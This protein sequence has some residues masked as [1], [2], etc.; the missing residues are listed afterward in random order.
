MTGHVIASKDFGTFYASS[1]R[2]ETIRTSRLQHGLR[3]VEERWETVFMV[4][5]VFLVGHLPHDR[6]QGTKNFSFAGQAIA[7]F[8]F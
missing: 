1:E 4:V 8:N 5:H 3:A 2:Q 7:L 6:T